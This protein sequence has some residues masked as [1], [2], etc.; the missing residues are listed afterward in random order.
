MRE[1][2]SVKSNPLLLIL[3]VFLL[4]PGIL[5]PI[6]YS[7][8]TQE[9]TNVHAFTVDRGDELRLWKFY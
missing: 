7:Y 2:I 9:S 5:E 6:R 1:V 4:V 3:F 8:D